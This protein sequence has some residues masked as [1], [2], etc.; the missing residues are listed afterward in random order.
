MKTIANILLT[1]LIILSLAPASKAQEDN[2]V[3]DSLREAF[4]STTDSQEKANI[5][6]DIS[7][8][9][10]EADTVIKYSTLALQNI[11]ITDLSSMAQCY[12]YLG[13]AYFIKSDFD[14][15]RDKYQR[16]AAMF[17]RQNL[18]GEASMSYINIAAC[19]R[20]MSQYKDMWDN[21]YRGLGIAQEAH[22]TINICY[23]YSEIADVYQNQKMGNVAQEMLMSALELATKK[24]NYAEMGS[25]AKQLGAI[26]TPEDTDIEG[27]KK[28]K[29]WALKAEEYFRK[30]ENIDQYYEAIRYNNYA[31]II[32][33][34]LTLAKFYYDDRYID[35]SKTY[36]ELYDNYAYNITGLPGDKITCLHIH[37]RQLMY[38]QKYKRAI[39]TLKQCIELFKEGNYE[40]ISNITYNLL[41]ESY[42]K[43]G[44]YGNAL[45]YLNK[46]DAVQQTLSGADAMA[47][48]I[49]YNARYK[50]ESEKRNI[51]LD[52]E[53]AMES[54][55]EKER[56]KQRTHTF[57]F[58]TIIAVAFIMGIIIFSWLASRR[59]VKKIATRNA[60]ILKQQWTI[61]DQKKELQET[62][63]KIRQSMAYARRI[64]VAAT[65]S[66][67][68]IPAA[69]PDNLIIYRPQEI[70]SGDW[71]WVKETDNERYVAVGGG[72]EHGVPGA[73]TCMLVADSLKEAVSKVP[74]DQKISPSEIL[75]QVE[76]KVRGSIGAGVEIAISFCIIDVNNLLRFS[77]IGN[78]AVLVRGNT[79]NLININKREDTVIQLIE[80]DY[81]FLYS[82]NTR[83][84]MTSTG[85]EPEDICKSLAIHHTDS[86]QTAIDTIT[87]GK[88]QTGDITIVGIGI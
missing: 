12:S 45:L 31:E 46:F 18:L 85:S 86:T 13:W 20:Y 72:N 2:S 52:N 44:D 40:Y 9:A 71:Y 61:D 78:D 33:C 21:L 39:E 57:I 38:E 76:N 6:L 25:Y 68:D 4:Y 35:S 77:A 64:Q 36:I 16:A 8:Q 83:R 24:G 22:D 1:M 26:S 80:G 73:M 66:Q 74:T 17:E 84:L 81:L 23:A 82:N 27:V 37:A 34:Y 3:V 65:S 55:Q 10:Y 51:E 43:I 58:V 29:E 19:F 32:Y 42:E 87:G 56:Q 54:Q 75:T 48:A 49:A 47:Q 15:S 60:L 69:F 7:A 63:E 30:A 70:V 59:A 62:S 41:A 67:E 5:C 14:K 11:D 88:P 50:I 79:S 53:M 28:A